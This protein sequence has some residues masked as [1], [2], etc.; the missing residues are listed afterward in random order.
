MGVCVC[1][2]LHLIFQLLSLFVLPCARGDLIFLYI[3]ISS[4]FVAL[5]KKL[6]SRW[7]FKTF[8]ENDTDM[9]SSTK[10]IFIAVLCVGRREKRIR[11]KKSP[12]GTF[13]FGF[14]AAGAVIHHSGEGP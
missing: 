12:C 1:A 5:K 11:E 2:F 10:R 3:Y 6:N 8:F 7:V 4:L 14:G 9:V 13:G